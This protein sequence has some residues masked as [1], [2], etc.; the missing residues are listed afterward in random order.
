MIHQI[1]RFGVNAAA[2]I[3]ISPEEFERIVAAKQGVGAVVAIEEKFNLLMENYAEFERE[4]LDITLRRVVFQDADWENFQN[5]IYLVNRRL[6]NLLSACRLHIDQARHAISEIYGK[7]SDEFE[8]MK[9]LTRAEHGRSGEYRIMDA[10]RNHIQH[11]NLPISGLVLTGT[12]VDLEGMP[13]AKHTIRVIVDV[14]SMRKDPK[15]SAK[16]IADIESRDNDG[17]SITPLVRRYVESLGRIHIEI[18]SMLTENFTAWSEELAAAVEQGRATF[19]DDVVGLV[20]TRIDENG[21]H[22]DSEHLL[23]PLGERKAFLERR[24]AHASALGNH[25]VSGEALESSDTL[26]P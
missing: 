10:I 17:V 13:A 1:T 18:R 8:M 15:V 24:T 21:G 9:K 5:D 16:V 25:Y 14:D 3:D 12:H 11:R 19:G 20:A 22:F 4:L 6:V 23:I 2:G 26:S 7:D